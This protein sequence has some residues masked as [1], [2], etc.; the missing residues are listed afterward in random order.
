MNWAEVLTIII[1]IGAIMGGVVMW[2]DIKHREDIARLDE[3]RKSDISNHREDMKAMD[4][5]W[6]WLFERTDNKLDQIRNK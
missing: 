5:R 6:K 1:S 4:E 3:S 2:L